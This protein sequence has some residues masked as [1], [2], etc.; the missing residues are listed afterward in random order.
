LNLDFENQRTTTTNPFSSFDPYIA[1]RLSFSVIQPLLRGRVTDEG[2]AQITIS[3]KRADLANVDFET[4]V[5]NVI[6]RVE[7]AYWDLVAAR[8]DVEVKEDSAKWARE[9]LAINKRLVASG[10]LAPVELSASEAEL[11]RRM[12]TWY[13]AIGTL[14]EVENALKTMIAPE[15]TAEI[16]GE[17]LIPTEEH[18]LDVSTSDDLH[19]AV[20]TALKNRTELRAVAMR[21]Q[22]N[23]VE[24]GLNADLR[25]PQVNLVGQYSLN[26]LAGTLRSGD[27]P[28]TASNGALYKQVNDLSVKAGL[29]P[30]PVT[31]FGS[32][33]EFLIG[34]YGTTLSNIFGGRYQSF[35]AG[36]QIDLNLRNHTADANYT[37]SLISEKRLK[38]E[39]ARAEQVIEAQVRNALQS[40][41][42]ARQRIAAAEASAQAAKEKLESEMRLYQTGESTNFLVLTRQNE[43]A[44]SRRRV[45][46]A[47]L[48]LNKSIA[49]L[50]QAL[51][52]TLTKHNVHLKK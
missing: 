35:Q 26:G 29:S 1:S 49:Q 42:T 38:L 12:D 46:V 33:P 14:T 9:Q 16:W 18:S 17:E 21:M 31:N 13:T 6:T 51:G 47:R 28:F 50:E 37:T 24:K 25:K 36:V 19:A 45:V 7:S 27:N 5:I 44:D 43:S 8:Q 23:D 11:Q 2:R 3:K 32:T 39:R 52:T 15:R 10:T 34:G 20:D 4:R 40:I 22:V 30:L 41:E 48:E